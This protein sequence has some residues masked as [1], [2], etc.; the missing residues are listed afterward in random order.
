VSACARSAAEEIEILAVGLP[1][2]GVGGGNSRGEKFPWR[3]RKLIALLGFAFVEGTGAIHFRA[4]APSAPELPVNENRHAALASRGGE[5]VGGNEGVD[6][7][8]DEGRFRCRQC[9]ELVRL[10]WGSRRCSRGLLRLRGTAWGKAGGNGG[11]GAQQ[12]IA[13]CDRITVV[14]IIVRCSFLGQGNLPSC[15]AAA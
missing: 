11:A 10:R 13:A 5:F 9:D 6:G 7:S 1:C 2:P 14:R 12:E 4:A 3:E 8:H 15:R